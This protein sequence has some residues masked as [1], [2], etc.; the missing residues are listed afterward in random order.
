M[1]FPTWRSTYSASCLQQSPLKGWNPQQREI[2]VGDR[3]KGQ[4]GRTFVWERKTRKASSAYLSEW[5]MN[6]YL[7]LKTTFSSNI[8]IPSRGQYMLKY[9]TMH[10]IIQLHLHIP[11]TPSLQFSSEKTSRAWMQHVLVLGTKTL[12]VHLLKISVFKCAIAV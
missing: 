9:S 8:I 2:L 4:G 3:E 1:T 11:V 7:Y 6:T 12:T 5:R 10:L